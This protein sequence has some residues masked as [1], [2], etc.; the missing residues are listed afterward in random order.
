MNGFD[1]GDVVR[2]AMPRGKDARGVLG[3]H[4]MYTT[5]QEAK[6]DGAV[7]EVVDIK[8]DGTH[9][10]ALYLVD[11]SGFEQK[12]EPPYTAY[13]IRADWLRRAEDPKPLPVDE[14][15]NPVSA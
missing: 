8:P 5:S 2:V 12:S 11:F 13:W 1:L 10:I 9:G 6:C 3:V 4:V 7:G 15:P 14:E